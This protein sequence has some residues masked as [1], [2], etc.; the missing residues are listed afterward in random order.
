MLDV[1]DRIYGDAIVK[2]ASQ[3]GFTIVIFKPFIKRKNS[4][5]LFHFYF[6]IYN[7]FSIPVFK[8]ILVNDVI[9]LK[10]T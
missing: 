2:K 8:P 4:K 6:Y 3:S 1:N 10:K 5:N 7:V 9:K